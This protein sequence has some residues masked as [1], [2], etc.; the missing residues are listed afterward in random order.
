MEFNIRMGK[1]LERFVSQES[2][3]QFRK[4][5][6]EKV[7][8]TNS[9]DDWDLSTARAV[10]RLGENAIMELE[11]LNKLNLN[12]NVRIHIVIYK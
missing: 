10:K 5:L 1:S 9:N 7:R 8:K 6:A 2:L 12:A 3:I 4:V 11:A